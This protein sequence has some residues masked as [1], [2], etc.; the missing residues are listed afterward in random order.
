M[1]VKGNYVINNTD[2]NGGITLMSKGYMSLVCGKERV[3]II[4]K[5]TKEPSGEGEATF[6]QKVYDDKG[7]LDKST[8]PGDYYFES[9]AGA[10]QI[11]SKKTVGS[12]TNQADGLNVTI[13]KGDETQ[14]VTK[15]NQKLNVTAGDRERQVGLN[16]TVN[17]SGILK[18]NATK[19]FL[20]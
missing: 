16:E 12:S 15:G 3:D 8:V 20:N 14:T 4:G 2:E 10:T 17:I 7:K 11:Y 9:A 5:Y 18:V 6:T 1:N 19:I 13:Q